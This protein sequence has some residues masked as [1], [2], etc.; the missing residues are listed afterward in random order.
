MT[1]RRLFRRNDGTRK[2]FGDTELKINA[3][4]GIANVLQEVKKPR[5]IQGQT[6]VTG[7]EIPDLR[8]IAGRVVVQIRAE[9]R[10][11]EQ[12]EAKK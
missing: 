7:M 12:S 1:M 9:G 10:D 8:V 4:H 11:I 2:D 5:T 6:K 3:V